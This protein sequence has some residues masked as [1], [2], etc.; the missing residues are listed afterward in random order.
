MD[1]K[2]INNSTVSPEKWDNMSKEESIEIVI[3]RKVSRVT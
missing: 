3:I 2:L 1:N